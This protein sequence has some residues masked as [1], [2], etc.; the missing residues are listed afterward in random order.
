MLIGTNL[1][2][3]RVIEPAVN[4]AIGI[5]LFQMF[6]ACSICVANELQDVPCCSSGWACTWS[7]KFFEL[8]QVGDSMCEAR[9]DLC[10]CQPLCSK[11]S[12]NVGSMR[13]RIQEGLKNMLYMHT[14]HSQCRSSKSEQYCPKEEIESHGIPSHGMSC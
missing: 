13:L 14:K 1:G 7:M 9:I 12:G 11:L 10:P 5:N 4:E 2:R 3:I 6:V 8:L